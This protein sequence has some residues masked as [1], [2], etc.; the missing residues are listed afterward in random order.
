[1]LTRMSCFYVEMLI[2]MSGLYVKMMIMSYF[3]AEILIRMSC[4]FVEM[5]IRISYPYVEMLIRIC[6]HAEVMGKN[7]TSATCHMSLCRNIDKNVMSLCR[8][9]GKNFHVEVFIRMSCLYVEVIRMPFC[10]QKC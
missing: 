2:R 1:M 4:L 3:H 8:N 9:N 7:A 10:M 6:L 5:M